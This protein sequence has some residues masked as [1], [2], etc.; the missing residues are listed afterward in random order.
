MKTHQQFKEMT[1]SSV[2]I[3]MTKEMSSRHEMKKETDVRLGGE[4]E[5]GCCVVSGATVKT[6]CL[7]PVSTH[8]IT[9]LYHVLI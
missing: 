9:Y 5:E 6:D 7:E 3:F 2:S 8:A 1:F 4:E